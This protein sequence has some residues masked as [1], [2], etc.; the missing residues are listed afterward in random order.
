M[1]KDDNKKTA[2]E[3]KVGE[4]YK[5][6]V[7]IKG[8]YYHEKVILP[9]VLRL[10]EIKA[11]DKI[12]DLACGQGIFGRQ[13][14]NLYL[15]VDL[16]KTLIDEAKKLDENPKHRYWLGDVSKELKSSII[17]DKGIIV[18]ALQ[19]IKKPFGVI[20]NFNKLLR[21]GGELVIV[22]N[23]PAF[24]VP[25]HSDWE[26]KN[27]KQYRVI[28]NYMSPL[29]IPIET[30]PFD[31]KDNQISYSYHYPLSAYFEML[32]SNG[33]MVEKIE[34]WISPKKS[35]GPMAIIED[36]ARREFPLFLAIKAIKNG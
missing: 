16:A 21:K 24:R 6:S 32:A 22:I 33:F 5:K 29:E 9:G 11:E 8:N 1:L 15:G 35:E 12:L 20:R 4:W 17:F 27:D 28:E 19:N 7:G 18:L 14:N 25:K 31:K 26:V 34:E 30:S 36:K 13:V 23:H 3:G 2:W 10:L